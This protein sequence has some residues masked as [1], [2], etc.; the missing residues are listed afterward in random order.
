LVD[1]VS[2]FGAE[3]IAGR[4]WHVDAIAATA[5]KCLH[6]VPGLSFVLARRAL[7]AQ[8]PAHPDSVYFDLH[9]Y[10]R[11]Q[12]GEGFS[13]FTQ[14]VQ[15]AFALREA[16]AEHAEAGGAAAR[17]A[18]YQARATRIGAA[19]Q[20]LGVTTLLDPVELSSVLWSYRLPSGMTYLR[21]HDAL[22]QRG[23]I[24]YAGQGH[25]APGVFRI[26]H[27]GDIGAADI[28]RLTTALRQAIGG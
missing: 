4:D 28:E 17:R 11:A 15:V 26:A 1:A 12:H 5:N 20:G 25:L 9:A 13:P 7:W 8:P 10:H 21:L 23:F 22:K 3:E 16:L 27:M 14:A 19:L 18:L 6:G 2:S 24:I